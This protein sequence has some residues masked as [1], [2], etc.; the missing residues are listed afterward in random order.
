MNRGEAYHQ[1]RRAIASVNGNRF[2]GSTDYEIDLW[3]D[4]A[5]LLTNAIIS[6]NSLILSK[7]LIRFE[8]SEQANKLELIKL[9]SP[10]AWVNINLVGTYSFN[11]GQDIQDLDELIRPIT[12]E[13][14]ALEN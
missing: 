14:A 3:N 2:R 11:V 5:R 7:L 6:L 8:T 4:C 12:Q 13:E 1:L 10:V 9:A